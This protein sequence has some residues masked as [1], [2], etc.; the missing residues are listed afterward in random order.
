MLY[1]LADIT[2]NFEYNDT[3]D[4][5][6]TSTIYE[7]AAEKN[8]DPIGFESLK[9]CTHSSENLMTKLGYFRAAKCSASRRPV[10]EETKSK[11]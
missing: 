11:H 8:A 3:F 4:P 6:P 5:T 1:K 10:Q 2:N 7:T 9:S